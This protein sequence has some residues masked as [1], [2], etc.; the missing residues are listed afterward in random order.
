MT[1]PFVLP[2]LKAHTEALIGELTLEQRRALA[3]RF[4]DDPRFKESTE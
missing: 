2:S 4:P 3:L 1:S